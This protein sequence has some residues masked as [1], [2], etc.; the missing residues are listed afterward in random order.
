MRVFSLATGL[1]LGIAAP[2]AARADD[3]RLPVPPRAQ[4]LEV[5]VAARV[6]APGSDSGWHIHHGV[7]IA[8]VAQGAVELRLANAP[9][10]LLRAGQSAQ[11]PRGMAHLWANGGEAPALIVSTYLRDRQGPLVIPVPPPAKAGP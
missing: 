7:E 9:I 4:G 5:E 10:R 1:M 3:M 2:P 8:Y 6:L 11:L